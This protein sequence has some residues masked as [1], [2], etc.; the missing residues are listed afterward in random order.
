VR[1]LQDGPSVDLVQ[2]SGYYFG[3]LGR[4]YEVSCQFSRDR[5]DEFLS[6]A[7]AILYRFSF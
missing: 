1:V 3:P 7:N 2:V 4:V 6:I 5:Q